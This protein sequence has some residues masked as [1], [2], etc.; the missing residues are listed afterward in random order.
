MKHRY[1]TAQM[2][3]EAYEKWL[4][5]QYDEAGRA[6]P[7]EAALHAMRLYF[8]TGFYSCYETISNMAVDLKENCVDEA[9]VKTHYDMLKAQY[10]KFNPF[11]DEDLN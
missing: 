1:F 5:H 2:A 10:E 6:R 11:E 9:T 4:F 7:N 3:W 8:K